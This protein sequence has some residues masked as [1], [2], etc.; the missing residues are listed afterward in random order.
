MPGKHYSE[1]DLNHTYS[2]STAYQKMLNT[3]ENLTIIPHGKDYGAWEVPR[4]R[5]FK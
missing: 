1:S 4:H 5:M 2:V 3:L